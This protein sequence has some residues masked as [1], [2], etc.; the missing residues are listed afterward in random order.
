MIFMLLNFAMY[1]I[2]D[3]KIMA[4]CIN[5][6]R[7]KIII[8]R[9]NNIFMKLLHILYMLLMYKFVYFQAKISTQCVEY[10]AT[11]PSLKMYQLIVYYLLNIFVFYLYVK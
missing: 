2:S 5:K 6:I 4:Y 11:G 1:S 3:I 10:I 8:F 9:Y 7:F